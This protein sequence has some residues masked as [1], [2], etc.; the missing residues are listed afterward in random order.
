MAVPDGAPGGHAHLAAHRVGK[1][2][3]RLTGWPSWPG[4]GEVVYWL[5]ACERA[6]GH[7][8]AALAAW[9][10]VPETASVARLAALERGR[11]RETSDSHSPSRAS[12]ARFPGRAEGAEEGAG[13]LLGGLYLVT[14]RLEEYRDL[15]R[16]EVEREPDPTANLPPPSGQ[17]DHMPFPVERS[18]PGTRARPRGRPRR[19]PRL[20]GP[21]RP[22]DP[23]GHFDEAEEWLRRA[24]GPDP[25]T[26]PSGMP[27]SAGPGGGPAR[28]SRP[29]GDHLPASLFSRGRVLEL[30][31]WLA[32]RRGDRQA[33]RAALEA[34]IA[35]EP[36]DPAAVERLADLAAQDGERE[37]S[38]SCGAARPP[39]SR[40]PSAIRR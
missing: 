2:K 17:I 12:S 1:A 8:D 24:S 10:R 39:S 31:A 3:A 11:R 7:T 28:R 19:R 37:R 20:A 38:P 21:G 27:G 5:G 18:S 34:R 25:P 29:G 4:R 22:G 23:T 35:L 15:S 40:A 36:A 33:E 13:R 9:G 14:G 6:V 26:L 32:A 16:R 30:R